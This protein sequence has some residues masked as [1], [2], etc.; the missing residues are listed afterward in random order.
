VRAAS[1]G[2]ERPFAPAIGI[3]RLRRASRGRGPGTSNA[4]RPPLRGPLTFRHCGGMTEGRLGARRASRR[5]TE[6]LVTI[7]RRRPS[8]AIAE[9]RHARNTRFAGLPVAPAG[10][11]SENC[12]QGVLK[13]Q[14]A[15]TPK[16]CKLLKP[17]GKWHR[18]FTGDPLLR[19]RW[20][21]RFA[22]ALVSG[23]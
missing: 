4:G 15:S 23:I 14:Q 9:G 12:R 22:S 13:V 11:C 1:T 20:M 19:R 21:C 3:D 8:A 5:W 16:F 2:R 6:P 18:V 10:N 7:L 17:Q